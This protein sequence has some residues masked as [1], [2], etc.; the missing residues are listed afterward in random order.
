[1]CPADAA[2]TSRILI[3]IASRELVASLA[4]TNR[5]SRIRRVL[6]AELTSD[7]F[8]PSESGAGAASDSDGIP[9]R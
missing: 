4:S 5:V 2:L 8:I 6:S 7:E 3:Q 9:Q 1:M